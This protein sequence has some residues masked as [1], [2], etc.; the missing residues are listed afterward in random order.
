MSQTFNPL[1][2]IE[3]KKAILNKI[4]S[5][6]DESDVFVG[7]I[8]YPWVKYDFSVSMTSYPKNAPEAEPEKVAEGTEELGEASVRS[9]DAE[10]VVI[11]PPSPIVIDTPDQAR[12]E[13]DLPI[14]TPVPV[15]GIGIVDKPVMQ[16]SGK[17]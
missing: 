12:V 4:E 13:A 14:P 3:L 2:G 15:I 17:K 16:K 9:K 8:T 5:S 11:A 1:T 6:M 10:R 7:N